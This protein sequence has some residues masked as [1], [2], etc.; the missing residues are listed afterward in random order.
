M[1]EYNKI[2]NKLPESVQ[3]L[4]RKIAVKQFTATM[5]AKKLD[6]ALETVNSLRAE[7]TEK[8]E[9]IET[10]KVELRDA[11]NQHAKELL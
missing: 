7:L 2:F 6:A 11:I 5:H 8:L 1:D 9:D 10:L 4:A 3:D